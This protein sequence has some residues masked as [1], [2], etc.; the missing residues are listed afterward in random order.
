M[1]SQNYYRKKYIR[2]KIKYL[3][4]KNNYL[5]MEMIG[6]DLPYITNIEKINLF[7]P[8]IKSH[9]DM[10]PY[11]NPIYGLI[12][13]KSGYIKNNFYL[14]DISNIIINNLCSVSTYLFLFHKYI[15]Q[16]C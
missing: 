11:L 5:N 1:Y 6:G 12:M 9:K 16:K 8:D 2:Y 14:L 4:L 3:E 13:C 15:L 7:N 10:E